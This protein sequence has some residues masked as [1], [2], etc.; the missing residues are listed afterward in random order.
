MAGASQEYVVRAPNENSKRFNVMR[1]ANS[2]NVDV[3]KWK[4]A[5]M[6]RERSVKQQEKAAT[7]E[8]PKFG[9]G[10]EYGKDA[11]EEARRKK[12]GQYYRKNRGDDFPWVLR[13]GGKNGKKFKGTR[14]GGVT[15]NTSYYVFFQAHDGAFEAFPVSE[16]YNFTAIPR[17]KPL[18]SEEAE[19]RYEERHK[20]Y[21]HFAVMASRKHTE[22]E[23]EQSETKLL[24]NMKKEKDFKVSDMDDWVDSDRS[25]D[26]SDDD[27]LDGGNQK[28][29]KGKGKG[30][31]KGAGKKKGGKKKKGS[32][33]DDDD[34]EPGEESD[35]GDQEAREVDYMSDLSSSSEEEDLEEKL[36]KELKGVEDEDA[37]RK[38]VLSDDD[39]DEEEEGK[40]KEDAKGLAKGDGDEVSKGNEPA[41]K[42]KVKQ[43]NK[44]SDSGTS[45]SDDSDDSDLD[46]SK[47]QSAMFLQKKS[48]STPKNKNGSDQ[49]ASSSRSN[50]PM[51]DQAGQ[52][53]NDNGDND[54]KSALKRK[55]PSAENS[56]SVNKKPKTN[57]SGSGG[58]AISED[59]VRRYLMRK[60]MTAAELLQKFKGRKVPLKGQDLVTTIA[61]ILK[62]LNPDKQ[63]IKGKLHLY[64]KPPTGP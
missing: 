19:E 34:S 28:N 61:F 35:E 7:E 60:P 50:T 46:D 1:F 30:K 29:G 23:G 20:I 14:E 27:E 6:E 39:D 21:N 24:K 26:G 44:S 17:Y 36:N 16:W 57:D 51:T 56:P 41:G 33:D 5:R 3:T 13:V 49:K 59:A 9:F 15:E 22:G 38:L 37:L 12:Y 31:A 40:D 53:N 63:T 42:V 64:I 11:K 43:E 2:L 18:T 54:S 32:D 10:S 55:L 52:S 62:K 58:E 48:G 4:V 47:F 8:A 45:A 25:G